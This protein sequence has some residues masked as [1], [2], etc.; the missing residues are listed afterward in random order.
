MNNDFEQEPEGRM[1]K[2]GGSNTRVL[3]LVLLLLVAVF[4]YLYYFTGLIK[5]REE[6]ATPAPAQPAQVKQPIPP[7]PEE[8]P[9]PAAAQ[10]E[11]AKTAAAP[12]TTAEQKPAAP[13]AVKP[14]EKKA[15]PAKPAQEKAKAEAPKPVK[16]E[17][18]Q[19]KKAA[20]KP[21]EKKAAKASPEKGKATEPAT[22]KKD[23]KKA[24]AAPA[25]VK[26]AVKGEEKKATAPAKAKTAKAAV[27][28]D[29][30]DKKQGEKG[31]GEY[32]LRIGEYVV[33]DSMAADKEKAQDAGL[34]PVVKQ[35]P[36]KKEPMVRLYL[37]EFA[38]Q[39]SARRELAKLREATVD[40][41]VLN[42]GGKYRVYAG[43]YFVE[44]RAAKERD[45]IAAK[46]VKLTLRKSAVAVPTYILTAGKFSNR[47]DAVKMAAKL[48]QKGLRPVVVEN[49]P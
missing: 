14:E 39:E 33:V 22:A 46:G 12:A 44:G 27:V 43:S 47:D 9:A 8:K 31:A 24:E 11:A 28:K 36:K 26:A 18:A 1:S 19:E 38:D 7:R 49:A 40:G 13:A 15:E 29:A 37:G 6:A 30:G 5:P 25:K 2:E 3:L 48:K 45:R 41:F 35:G 34:T 10:P 4:G 32:T 20:A 42:E 23:A 17:T 21:D 16:P